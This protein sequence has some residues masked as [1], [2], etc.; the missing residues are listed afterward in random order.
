MTQS[1]GKS[2]HVLDVFI[3]HQGKRAG[4][5]GPAGTGGDELRIADHPCVGDA[6]EGDGDGLQIGNR[7][8][9]KG[10]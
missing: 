4:G 10:E 9:S 1:A 2:Q 7:T 3:A 8:P 5:A 6:S